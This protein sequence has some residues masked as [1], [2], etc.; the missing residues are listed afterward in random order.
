[1]IQEVKGDLFDPSWQFDAIAHGV[2]CKGAMGAGIAKAFRENYPHMYTR[3]KTMCDQGFL[4]PGQ[5]MPWTEGVV[6]YNIASQFHPGPD[7]KVEYLE[8]GLQWVR[9][10]MEYHGMTHLGLPWIG[11]GI[12]GLDYHNDVEPVVQFVFGKSDVDVTLVEFV[13]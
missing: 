12:G 4:L 11:A 2:N 6:V 7:A 1:M 13:P 10:H 3:Y 9:F 8:A 5:V